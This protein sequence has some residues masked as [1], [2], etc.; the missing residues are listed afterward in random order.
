MAAKYRVKKPLGSFS[1][2]TRIEL[3]AA[4]EF[5]AIAQLL[6]NFEN[7]NWSLGT[8]GPKLFSM[9]TQYE[10][11]AWLL[12]SYDAFLME[13]ERNLSTGSE[14][15]YHEYDEAAAELSTENQ[16]FIAAYTSLVAA[17]PSFLVGGPTN[18]L[19]LIPNAWAGLYPAMV[20]SFTDS[21]GT[22]R[23]FVD[24]YEYEKAL[25]DQAAAA[26]DLAAELE[27]QNEQEKLAEIQRQTELTRL[28]REGLELQNNLEG[29]ALDAEKFERSQ[30]IVD[31]NPAARPNWGYDTVHD[32]ASWSDI[33]AWS[34]IN[35]DELAAA[36]L[37][38]DSRVEMANRLN[39]AFQKLVGDIQSSNIPGG[40]VAT[41]TGYKFVRDATDDTGGDGT[42]VENLVDAVKSKGVV[43]PVVLVG[44]GVLLLR[45]IF[46]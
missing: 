9:Y 44:A 18:P 5:A 24:N 30:F 33:A 23:G 10:A 38:P 29:A 28:K 8:T 34:D 37:T 19:T 39:A 7:R 25:A 35:L 42:V 11:I 22:M 41:E 36:A 15:S 4:S 43:L 26:A 17:L 27:L 14:W 32:S 12:Y 45:K 21:L 16:K 31:F 40:W 1:A 6:A 13:I 20:K 46:K 2:D 3:R